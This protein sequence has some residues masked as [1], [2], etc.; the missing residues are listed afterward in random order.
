MF[1][2]CVPLPLVLST[3]VCVKNHSFSVILS[4]QN[5]ASFLG[6]IQLP[7]C[8][9][10]GTWAC[11]QSQWL[12]IKL[13]LQNSP[14]RFP[15]MSKSEVTSVQRILFQNVKLIFR[16]ENDYWYM[17]P[18]L[19]KATIYFSQVDAFLLS[20][21][22]RGKKKKPC[23]LFTP[24]RAGVSTNTGVWGRWHHMESQHQCRQ[25]EWLVPASSSWIMSSV[26]GEVWHC[27]S[28]PEERPF[29]RWDECS[30]CVTLVDRRG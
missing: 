2:I 4:F 14:K 20:L 7:L 26:H 17:S 11:K 19:H 27:S 9:L 15:M 29:T 23:W 8:I 3:E 24:V 28:R 5:D 16:T 1:F 30:F 10:R 6:K 18:V 21:Q 12:E 22:L 13:F 25:K